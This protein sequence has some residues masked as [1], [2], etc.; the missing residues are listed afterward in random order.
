MKGCLH[1]A[2]GVRAYLPA[3][4][5]SIFSLFGIVASHPDP[6]CT[7]HTAEEKPQ[8]LPFRFRQPTPAVQLVFRVGRELKTAQNLAR[9]S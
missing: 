6:D 5:V 2:D 4:T 7:D 9:L 1:Q 3:W 8:L